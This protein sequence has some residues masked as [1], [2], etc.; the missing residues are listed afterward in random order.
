MGAPRERWCV[1]GAV[2]GRCA[3]AF[4]FALR[5]ALGEAGTYRMGETVWLVGGTPS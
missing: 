2:S 5:L 4:L 3:Y 1:G